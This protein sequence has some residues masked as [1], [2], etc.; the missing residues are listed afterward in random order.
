MWST[1]TKIYVYLETLAYNN[2]TSSKPSRTQDMY[3][4]QVKCDQDIK[5][6]YNN[7]HN[8]I[9]HKQSLENDYNEH[10]SSKWSSEHAMQLRAMLKSIACPTNT[11]CIKETKAI[12]NRKQ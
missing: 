6:I 3:K 5:G 9:K 2:I 1:C 11:W 12:S 7:K 8:L 4:E 10:L